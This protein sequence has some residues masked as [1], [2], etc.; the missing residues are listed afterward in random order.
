ML[1]AIPSVTYHNTDWVGGDDDDD[2]QDGRVVSMHPAL[3]CGRVHDSLM[4][5]VVPVLG[6]AVGQA[7]LDTAAYDGARFHAHS[8]HDHSLNFGVDPSCEGV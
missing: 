7:G 2:G 1:K 5:R 6:F 4:T 3:C 8:G